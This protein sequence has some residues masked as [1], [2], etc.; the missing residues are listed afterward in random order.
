METI[1]L[2]TIVSVTLLYWMG[3]AAP[4]MAWA[5]LTPPV[6][7]NTINNIPLNS[8]G[9]GIIANKQWALI[10]GKALFWDMQAGSDNQACASCH[11]SAGADSRIRNQLSPGFLRKPTEDTGFGSILNYDGEIIAGAQSGLTK[12]QAENGNYHSLDATYTLL[13]EDFPLHHIADYKDRNSGILISTNDTVSSSGSYDS[14][15]GKIKRRKDIEKCKKPD[16]D[17]FYAGRY[18]ARQVEPRNTPTTI[19]AAFNFLNFFDGRANHNFNGVDP[20]GKRTLAPSGD[21]NKRLIVL[22]NNG[23]PTLGSLSIENAGLASQ[24]V[25]PPLSELEMSCSGKSFPDLGKKML[26][27]TLRPLQL[28][29]VDSTDSVFGA[30]G[31]IGNLVHYSGK[32]LGLSYADLIKLAFED[33]Y[34]RAN[35]KYKIVNGQLQTKNGSGNKDYYTQMESNFSM[36]WGLAIQMYEATLI[37]DKTP[38][39]TWFGQCRPVVSN[40]TSLFTN[41]NAVPIN[42]PTVRCRQA[43]SVNVARISATDVLDFNTDGI[44]DVLDTNSDGIVDIDLNNDTLRNAADIPFAALAAANLPIID[45]TNLVAGFGANEVLGFGVFNNG[46]V[47]IRDAGSPACGGCH[48]VTSTNFT[49]ASAPGFLFPVFSEAQFQAGQNFVPVERSRIDNRGPGTPTVIEGGVHDR[50]FFNIGVTPTAFDPGI[51]GTDPYGKPLSLARMFISEQAGEAVT[52]PSGVLT[53][54][55]VLTTRCNTPTLVEPGGTPAFPGCPSDTPPP[56]DKSLERDLVDG[57]FKTPTLR[58]IALTPPYFHNGGYSNLR[59]VVEFYARGGSRRDKSLAVNGYTGDT[60]GTGPLGKNAIPVAGADFGSNVDFFVRD[61]KSTDQQIDAIVAF[62]Q[63]LT[64][65]NVRC[66]ASV[67]DHPEL[68]V[69]NGHTAMD[70]NKDKKADD[71]LAKVS[72]VG[73]GGYAAAGRPDLCLPNSGDLFDDNLRKR[74]IP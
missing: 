25:G 41:I 42:N 71:I 34:W 27:D 35:K 15:F 11:F 26:S 43:G 62:M 38:F 56:L 14:V 1:R 9:N 23:N 3:M 13:E 47:G 59:Q 49:S 73:I 4:P 10:L 61:I 16:N 37:S 8:P 39:D 12:S 52:D 28:Q 18:A 24:A 51:G 6:P 33:K 44:P 66:D 48:P 20:F 63:T 21:P 67:F 58:N 31:P 19:N 57:G 74:L 40:P 70:S 64:D 22:D 46:G 36:F 32:G 72:A 68:F 5:A 60:S 29:K 45:P 50:G 30:P 69:F 17:V 2:K 65:E 7:V 54:S 55:G 53:S